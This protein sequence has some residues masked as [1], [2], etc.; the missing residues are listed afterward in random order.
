MQVEAAMLGDIKHAA[1][2]CI[3]TSV[4]A[5]DRSK[6]IIPMAP[7][8]GTWKKKVLLLQQCR[9]HKWYAKCLRNQKNGSLGM[10]V[11]QL[12]VVQSPDMRH[13]CVHCSTPVSN[14]V[15]WQKCLKCWGVHFHQAVPDFTA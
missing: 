10:Q 4:P 15:Q 11:L 2:M 12:G 8:R 5:A 3:M 14:K 13:L 1:A 7:S 9:V 6:C